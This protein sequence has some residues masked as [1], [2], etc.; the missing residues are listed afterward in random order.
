[1]TDISHPLT[2]PTAPHQLGPIN[3][4]VTPATPSTTGHDPTAI[5]PEDEPYT[6]KCICPFPDDDGSTVL[7]DK[8]GTWQHIECYYYPSNYVPEVHYCTDC[9][10]TKYDVKAAT[11]RQRRK[12]EHPGAAEKT[13]RPASKSHKKKPKDQKQSA[14]Q[15]DGWPPHDK[16]DALYPSDPKSVSPRD[17]PPAKRPKIT[18]KN[19]GSTSSHVGAKSPS[20]GPSESR[21]V[22]RALSHAAR[23][24]SKSPP[25]FNSLAVEDRIESYTYTPEFM[26]LYK[27]DPG[28]KDSP[29]NVYRSIDFIKQTQSWLS[30]PAALRKACGATSPSEIFQQHQGID[31]APLPR[32]SKRK[33]ED[34]R[35]EFYGSHPVWMYLTADSFI[36]AGSLIGELKGEMVGHLDNYKDDGRNRWKTL[37]HPE[38]FVFFHPRLPVYIDTRKEG[39]LLRY[40]RRSCRPNLEMKILVTNGTE[41]HYCFV[42]TED[43]HPNSELTVAWEYLPPIREYL[44]RQ[45]AVDQDNFARDGDFQSA[46]QWINLVLAN[47]GGCACESNAECAFSR[48]C[49]RQNSAAPSELSAVQANGTKPRKQR[50]SKNPTPLHGT[51]PMETSRASSEGPRHSDH[52]DEQ[53]DSRST[54]GSIN[55]KSRSRDLTPATHLSSD[56]PSA[57]L[58][59]T[60]LSDREKRKIAAVEKTFERLDE[61]QGP[62]KKKRVSGGS[63]LNSSGVGFF[64]FQKQQLSAAAIRITKLTRSFHQKQFP[65]SSGPS[66][67]SAS[68]PNTPAA[69]ALRGVG[70]Y[71]DAGT[72]QTQSGSPTSEFPQHRGLVP[73]SPTKSSPMSTSL[74]GT[75][76]LSSPVGRPTNYQNASTQTD[77]ED[78]AW[79]SPPPVFL[80]KKRV[81]PYARRLLEKCQE[82]RSRFEIEKKRKS[83]AIVISNDVAAPVP[84]PPPP[85]LHLHLPLPPLPSFD[86][87]RTEGQGL[88]KEPGL[89]QNGEWEVTKTEPTTF[90]PPTLVDPSVYSVMPDSAPP[91]CDGPQASPPSAIQPLDPNIQKTNTSNAFKVNPTSEGPFRDV[92]S[93]PSKMAHPNTIGNG[94]SAEFRTPNSNSHRPAD[95]RLQPTQTPR[96]GDSSPTTPSIQ[97]TPSSATPTLSLQP[98]FVNTKHSPSFIKNNI[99]QAS[100]VKKK[101]SLSEYAQRKKVETPTTEKP[102]SAFEGPNSSSPLSS[103]STS[104]PDGILKPSTSLAEETKDLGGVNGSAMVESP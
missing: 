21:K 100:P 36:P 49:Y 12:R 17:Q 25:P 5:T 67:S 24:P 61:G 8:C 96:L 20:L 42:A 16:Q 104:A 101:L 14:L 89:S 56:V 99:A 33:K 23:S 102:R 27:R 34:H 26:Q 30:D 62:K 59:G 69:L 9:G 44:D 91:S 92:E 87:P 83:D 46:A 41:W 88:K 70:G 72:S 7:C 79:Y 74:A 71:M 10:G 80:P 97:S 32:I 4:Q 53:D 68:L 31:L 84:T 85:P 77:P 6:I 45:A 29:A 38:P 55:S 39:T 11:E 52:R 95:L 73:A 65:S 43:I 47:F 1:M 19:S 50:R 22:A 13:K 48:F 51:V 94:N 86:V 18:H 40:V 81:I 37:R 63:N 76:R 57:T 98:P 66:L 90:P 28:D 2:T 93:T 60:E 82:D 58:A 103:S 64:F 75:P 54:S 15:A 35:V 3:A 78:D